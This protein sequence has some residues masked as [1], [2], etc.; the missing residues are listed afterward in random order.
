MNIARRFVSERKSLV[1]RRQD[2]EY[3]MKRDLP[4]TSGCKDR[5]AETNAAPFDN[6]MLR[7]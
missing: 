3:L 2:K 1:I 7:F 6:Y 4:K 5:Q